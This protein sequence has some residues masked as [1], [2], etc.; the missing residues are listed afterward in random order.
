M[1]SRISQMRNVAPMSQNNQPQYNIDGVRALMQQYKNN[2][3]PQSMITNLLQQNPQ[4]GAISGMLR[5]GN[6]LEGIARQMAQ[7]RGIDISQ[8][9]NQLQGGM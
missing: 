1:A 5:N 9:I 6:S 2:P 4:L 7:T 3:D 8:L